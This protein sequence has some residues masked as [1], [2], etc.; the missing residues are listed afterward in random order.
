MRRLGVLE[1]RHRKAVDPLRQTSTGSIGSS[2]SPSNKGA[3]QKNQRQLQQDLEEMQNKM[4]SEIDRVRRST[5]LN[6]RPPDLR[7][8]ARRHREWTQHR[9]STGSHL[10]MH[11]STHRSI[12]MSVS[13]QPLTHEMQSVD[14][15]RKAV[16]PLHSLSTE[17]VGSPLSPSS[18]GAAQHIERLLQQELD[19][20]GVDRKPFLSETRVPKY[21]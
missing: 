2:S 4:Q 19:Q 16:N 17:S 20:I 13:R 10:S 7:G 1:D 14:R 8:S 15:L 3:A 5:R 18:T 21:I 11:I 6:Y 9:K 12:H